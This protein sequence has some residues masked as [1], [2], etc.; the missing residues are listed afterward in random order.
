MEEKLEEWSSMEVQR[1]SDAA[2]KIAAQPPKAA[3]R[4]GSL[5]SFTSTCE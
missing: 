2:D 1:G 3:C 4:V 5:Q